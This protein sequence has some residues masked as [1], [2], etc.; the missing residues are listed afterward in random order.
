MI[1]YVL[2]RLPRDMP[3]LMALLERMDRAS[4]TA[5]R[6]I[7]LPFVRALLSSAGP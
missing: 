3:S 7:T 2:A 5:Q 1:A 6:R 4:L